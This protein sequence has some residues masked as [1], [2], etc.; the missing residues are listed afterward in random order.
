MGLFVPSAFYYNC[1]VKC[2]G[3][4]EIRVCEG[5]SMCVCMCGVFMR[6][7]DE[8]SNILNAEGK[9][10]FTKQK[11]FQALSVAKSLSLSHRIRTKW[12]PHTYGYTHSCTHDTHK[13][14]PTQP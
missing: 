8:S 6:G 13:H 11:T 4:C 7:L 2:L 9:C 1:M 5:V 10:R 3:R 12:P 14:T